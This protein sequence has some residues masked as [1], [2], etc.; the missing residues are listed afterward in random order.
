MPCK[1]ATYRNDNSVRSM[2]EHHTVVAFVMWKEELGRS[3]QWFTWYDSKRET[4]GVLLVVKYFGL[5][6][7]TCFIS[8]SRPIVTH[9]GS[10]YYVFVFPISRHML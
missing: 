8:L 6:M 10:L 7:F 3:R 5:R 1:G 9:T 4:S 2:K